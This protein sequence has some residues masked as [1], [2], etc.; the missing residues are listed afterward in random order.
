MLLRL[1]LVVFLEKKD[2]SFDSFLVDAMNSFSER[3]MVEIRPDKGA[4]LERA[5]ELF[6]LELMGLNPFNFE[7]TPENR[8][9]EIDFP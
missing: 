8:P 5:I 7:L 1:C 6:H 9:F 4:G 2:R 3:Y